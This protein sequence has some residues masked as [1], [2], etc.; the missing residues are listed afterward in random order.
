MAVKEILIIGA[1]RG[2]G[3]HLAVN[4]NVENNV[5]GTYS[6]LKPDGQIKFTHLNLEELSSVTSFIEYIPSNLDAIIFNAGINIRGDFLEMTME[7]YDK[8]MGVNL[9][10]YVFLIQGLEKANKLREGSRLIFVSSVSSQYYGPTT[11]H[12]MLSKVGINALV[13]FL[14]QRYAE[15]NIFVNAVA[16]GLIL[17][18]QTETEFKSGAALRLIE[19]TLLKRPGE[20]DD[21]LTAVKY[22]L[23]ENNKYLTGQVLALSG[24]AIL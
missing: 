17:T 23:D 24:G 22:L 4:L 6:N 9:R 5:L 21:I 10:S 11:C 20:L 14:A 16:P 13:K 15:R 8:V 7:D 3:K 2:I 18:D 12:Y 19:K 1:S